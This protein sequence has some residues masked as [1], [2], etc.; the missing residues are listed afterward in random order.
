MTDNKMNDAYYAALQQLQSVDFSL[1]ELNLYLDTHP[2]DNQAMRQY[3]ELRT[4]RQMIVQNFENQ[5]GPLTNFGDTTSTQL[6]NV[7]PW[8]WQV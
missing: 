4:Q 6:W 7:G 5:F 2:E 1:V 3:N 8:P